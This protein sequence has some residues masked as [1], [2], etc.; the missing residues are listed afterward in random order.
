MKITVVPLV[1]GIKFYRKSNDLFY[2]VWVRAIIYRGTRH[3]GVMAIFIM[4]DMLVTQRL[5]ITKILNGK[6][7]FCPIYVNFREPI[8]HA[9]SKTREVTSNRGN[10]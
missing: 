8:A 9:P 10:P 3:T 6:N 5:K 2:F 1:E 4:H 7:R